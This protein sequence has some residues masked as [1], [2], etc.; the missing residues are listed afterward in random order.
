MI[1]AAIIALLAAIAIP[2]AVNLLAFVTA[3]AES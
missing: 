1:V 3:T 2:K